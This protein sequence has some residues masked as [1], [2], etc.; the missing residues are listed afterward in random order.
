MQNLKAGRS[1]R[2]NSSGMEYLVEQLLGGGGQ[3]EVYR[4][5][6]G[7]YPVALK[8]YFAQAA[9]PQQHAI[10]EALMKAGSPSPHFLWPFDFASV[11]GLPGFGYLMPL[12]GSRFKNIPDLLKR[13][14]DVT[15]ATHSMIG[16]N[17]AHGFLQLHSK[18]LCYQDI[19]DGNVFFD[20]KSGEVLICDNDNVTVN[21]QDSGTM[22]GTPRYMAP[23]IVRGEALP[24]RQTDLFSL[25]VLLFYLLMHGHP[26]NGRKEAAIRDMNERAMTKLY[27]NEPVFIF[28]PED[29]SNRP[30]PGYQDNPKEFWNIYPRF[31]QHLFIRAFTDGLRDP[32][33]GRVQE[34]EWRR[35][36]ARLRDSI[37]YCQSCQVQNPVDDGRGQATGV[38]QPVTCWNCEKVV[39]L[40][41][42][43]L[44]G[45]RIVYLNVDTR[46]FPHHVDDDRMYDFSSPVAEVTRHP[47]KP[48]L[49]GLRNLTADA[50]MVITSDEQSLPIEPGEN[51][52]LKPG[53]RIH[54]GKAE[55]AIRAS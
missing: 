38:R 35:A 39:S 22:R 7:D 10:L 28:D 20:P 5:R 17:L 49:W 25:S 45:K 50:W 44:L 14:V 3:G 26:L 33:N 27:G 41:M 43:M 4:V 37:V 8:W 23:E 19:S 1:V 42:H 55:G 40:P 21:G 2:A 51:V 29:D 13:R 32:Q 53:I 46:L 15:L 16:M 54:F 31:I 30:V 18:G 11:P 9:T 12:R 52:R 34:S 36:L 24:S 48:S 6:T 47:Q